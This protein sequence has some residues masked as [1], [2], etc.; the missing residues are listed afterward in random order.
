MAVIEQTQT[1]PAMTRA[2]S[3]RVA[4]WGGIFFVV[5]VVLQN[6]TR[7]AVAPQNDAP[8]P[9]VLEYF[10]QHRTLDL[11]LCTSFALGAVGLA[12]FL[13][14]LMSKIAVGPARSW[15][16]MGFAGAV[17]VIALFSTLVGT[18]TALSVAANRPQ[19]SLGAMDALWSLHN[20][21][22]AVLC[23]SIGVA[24]GGLGLACVAHELLPRAFTWLAPIGG[25][26]LAVGAIAAPLV[27]DGS[28]PAVLGI[29]LIGFLI[30]LIVV[31]F[32]GVR[33]IREAEVAAV[34]RPDQ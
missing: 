11:L 18:E 1:D 10:A 6:L 13:G 32:V 34:R 9:Q 30:W 5:I 23:L 12:L 25:C 3:P 31:A 2:I 21:I 16:Y 29:M 8:I 15:A 4:G 26:L 17:G 28:A 20:G 7:G 33:L 14:G 27:A 22:F 19:P 24:L